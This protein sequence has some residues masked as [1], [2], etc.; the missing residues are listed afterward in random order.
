MSLADHSGVGVGRATRV[1]PLASSPLR[2]RNEGSLTARTPGK[3]TAVN[4]EARRW[5]MPG[6]ASPVQEDAP[7][8]FE[9]S[10][11]DATEPHSDDAASGPPT[12]A[13]GVVAGEDGAQA[14]APPVA[15]GAAP[16]PVKDVGGVN[17]TTPEAGLGEMRGA[18]PDRIS[19][20]VS[21][22]H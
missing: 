9:S 8:T 16:K 4:A 20:P 6:T 3:E 15:G 18:R 13:V 10:Q 22:T 11:A 17:A 14:A 21:Y 5:E 12:D 2:T 1:D 19:M 7:A